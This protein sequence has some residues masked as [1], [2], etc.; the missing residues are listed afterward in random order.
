MKTHIV[1]EGKRVEI[2]EGDIFSDSYYESPKYFI[3]KE[4]ID[5]DDTICDIVVTAFYFHDH[6]YDSF[7][8]ND[9]ELDFQ[10]KL[11]KLIKKE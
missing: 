10:V 8:L 7:Y 11:V 3:I 5:A 1:I 4:I 6:R 2:K 9:F